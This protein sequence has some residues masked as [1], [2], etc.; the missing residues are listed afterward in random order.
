M[1]W[2]DDALGV[3]IARGKAASSIVNL[4]STRGGFSLE[5]AC[6]IGSYA[7]K[8]VSV[9]PKF[10]ISQ[11]EKYFTGAGVTTYKGAQAVIDIA[12]TALKML[13]K[14]RSDLGSAQLQLE[15][16][17][18]NISSTKTNVRFSESQIRDTDYGS[19]IQEFKQKTA[20]LSAG[21]YA[22]IQSNNTFQS[23][24]KLLQY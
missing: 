21:N 14:I 8:N 7:N 3:G 23:I 17:V 12:D 1:R 5:Q 18:R 9:L 24:E 6:A 22:L 15:A 20:L 10:N 2:E 4:R 19:E 16:T 11:G 13:E